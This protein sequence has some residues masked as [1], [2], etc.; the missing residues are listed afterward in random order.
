MNKNRFNLRRCWSL[1]KD[2]LQRNRFYILLLAGALFLILVVVACFSVLTPGMAFGNIPELGLS[3]AQVAAL[4]A[5][6][7]IGMAVGVA[8]VVIFSRVFA[9]MSMRSGEISYL[10]LPAT[11]SEKWLSRVVYVVLVGLALV[12]AVYYLAVLCC[13][14]LGSL[15]HV[16]SLSLMMKMVFDSDCVTGLFNF[17]LPWQASLV[18]PASTF[19]IMAAFV[20]GGTWFRRLPWLY[21]ALILLG[22]FF[23]VVITGGFGFGYY[24][25]QHTEIKAVIEDLAANHNLDGLFAYLTPWFFIVSGGVLLVLG[26]VMF[27]LSYRLFC[28]RQLKSQ[29]ILMLKS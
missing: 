18:N 16:E 2:D 7:N 27:W 24:I 20:L 17:H 13:G 9:N 15:F 1:L 3:S 11:N 22:T 6:S 8:E 26:I 23:V 12:M 25:S 28:R 14:L 5:T 21:T 29:R 4:S 19:F 10:M